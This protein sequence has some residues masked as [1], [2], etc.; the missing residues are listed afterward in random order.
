LQANDL[1]DSGLNSIRRLAACNI[2]VQRQ[3][4]RY[5]FIAALIAALAS[6]AAL[7]WQANNRMGSSAHYS[8]TCLVL[9]E[10]THMASLPCFI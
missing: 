4:S 2:Y 5:M 9:Q 6:S 7:Q 8:A 1:L 10:L 3:N